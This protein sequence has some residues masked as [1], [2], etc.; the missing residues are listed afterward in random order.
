MRSYRGGPTRDDPDMQEL[1]A[2]IP[3]VFDMIADNL[4]CYLRDSERGETEP[5]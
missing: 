5:A 1:S 3:R 2:Y 4:E